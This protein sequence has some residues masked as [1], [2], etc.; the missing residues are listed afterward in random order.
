[1]EPAEEEKEE[2]EKEEKMEEDTTKVGGQA[3]GLDTPLDGLQ[4]TKYFNP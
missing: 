2:E 4:V 1:M 3:H